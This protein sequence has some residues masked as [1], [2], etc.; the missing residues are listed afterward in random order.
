MPCII[1]SKNNCFQIIITNLTKCKILKIFAFENYEKS[2]DHNLENYVLGLER[3]VLDS[4]SELYRSFIVAT[5]T[6][7]PHVITIRNLFI[8]INH[9][10]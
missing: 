3:C 7:K 2:A 10:K 9:N 4:T 5:L 1:T 6:F 8:A